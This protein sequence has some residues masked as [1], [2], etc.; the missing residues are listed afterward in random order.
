[1]YSRQMWCQNWN[2]RSEVSLGMYALA[3]C[4]TSR[5]AANAALEKSFWGIP[6]LLSRHRRELQRQQSVGCCLCSWNDS[7]IPPLKA[8]NDLWTSSF[9][10]QKHLTS[11]TS[12]TAQT[13]ADRRSARSENGRLTTSRPRQSLGHRSTDTPPQGARTT[14]TL[15]AVFH[16]LPGSEF[17]QSEW[18]HRASRS[19]SSVPCSFSDLQGHTQV[20][21]WDCSPG[22]GGMRVRM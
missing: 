11:S 12:A 8:N 15:V 21:R 16:P 1:M 22:V 3:A 14:G 5:V 17:A 9:V 4:F 13:G 19:T 20:H 7:C 2:V 6:A 10:V 18:H